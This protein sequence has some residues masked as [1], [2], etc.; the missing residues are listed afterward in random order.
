M[1]AATESGGVWTRTGSRGQPIRV[2]DQ[3]PTFEIVGAYAESDGETARAVFA[4]W[5]LEFYE[6]QAYE[7]ELFLA[8]DESGEFAAPTISICKPR[9][10]GKSYAARN[11]AIWMAA[12]KG[13]GV[14]YSAHNADTTSKMFNE[15]KDVV[16]G[17][18]ELAADLDHGFGKD[19]SGVYSTPGRECVQF[20]NGGSIT[21]R[22][23]TNSGGRGGTNQILIIDEAQEL[24]YLQLDALS[25]TQLATADVEDV[26][27]GVQ[28][29]LIGTPT[30]P[31]GGGE[32]FLDYHEQAHAGTGG[33]KWW[34]EWAVD[35]PPKM[36]DRQAVLETAYR[37]NPAMGYR[38]RESTMLSAIDEYTARPENFA[39]EYLGWWSPRVGT[40][41]AIDPQAWTECATDE[42]ATEGLMGVGVKFSADGGRVCVAACRRV[43]NGPDY[44]ELLFDEPASHG[45]MWLARW[46]YERRGR[47]AGL[48][49]DGNAGAGDLAQKL[50]ASNFP[51]RAL[52][53]GGTKTVADAA[54]MLTAALFER[55]VTHWA[56]PGQAELDDSAITSTRRAVG[57]GIGF[58]GE[59]ATPIEAA[60]L[61]LWAARTTKFN[62]GRRGLAA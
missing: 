14:L 29:I 23:R 5:G 43:D 26:D 45:S 52:L 53:R 6:A 33:G 27:G 22:T 12:T 37:V 3:R 50:E 44:I 39:R 13:A 47:I 2:G 56:D 24:T 36:T 19:G 16:L 58:G 18:P 10:N 55:D 48:A 31:A 32:V 38:I 46:L 4:G 20:A 8:R 35:E 7:F 21:F 54:A 25:P 61:A 60:S 15:I 51:K 17:V 34:L 57:G 42:P 9:Q 1:R 41:G 11:Y 59:N 49:I 30:P 28:K 40:A 62:P